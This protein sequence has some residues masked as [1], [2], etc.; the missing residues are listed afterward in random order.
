[1]SDGLLCDGAVR[2]RNEVTHHV[3]TAVATFLDDAVRKTARNLSALVR[4]LVLA[5]FGAALPACK[6]GDDRGKQA[7]ELRVPV[8]S[9]GAPFASALYQSLGVPLQPGHDVS[10]L[11]NGAIFDGLE[12]EIGRARKSVHV[13]LYIWEKGAAS[14]RIVGALTA[15]DRAN[16]ACRIL[17]DD[18]GSP[19]FAKNVKPTLSAAG[20]EVRVFRPLPGAGDKLA[21]NHRK[22]VV[23][24]GRVGFTGG[25]GI[26][27]N[28]LGD[29]V[30]EEHWRDTNVRFTGPAVAQAQ[31]AFAE[32]WQ[33]AGGA[34]LPPDAFPPL[35]PA[36]SSSEAS[37]AIVASTVS[38][39]LTRSE[40]LVQLMI[41][42]ATKRLWIANAY[43]VPSDAIL[44]MIKRKA[45]EGVD[46]RLLAPGKKSDSTTSYAAQHIEY[47]EMIAKGVKVWEYLPSMMHAKTM[48]VDDELSLVGS[49]NL[50][51]LSLTKLEEVALV[52]QDRELAAKLAKRFELDCTHARRLSAD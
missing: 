5:A 30:T 48:V 26:R 17:V 12:T 50:E 11:D 44:A 1:M 42:A 2:P 13:V 14:D 31:Q 47:D 29:G 34:L 33:E 18:I 43:F 10:L 27:D 8:P 51:P 39:V 7:F 32:N 9:S 19:D 52:V 37:A 15:R 6:Q 22:I 40:R 38:P 4:V 46:V 25:F 24:D 45:S 20:C 3:S 41:Q 35:D 49:I 21:R 28:W 23:V 16:V 36:A